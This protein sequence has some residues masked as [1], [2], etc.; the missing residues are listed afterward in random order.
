MKGALKLGRRVTFKE[1][2]NAVNVIENTIV[3]SGQMLK[4][5]HKLLNIESSYKGTLGALVRKVRNVDVQPSYRPGTL[6]SL[7][8]LFYQVTFC[9]LP[10]VNQSQVRRKPANQ[11]IN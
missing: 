6:S 1:K 5:N 7:F 11:Q 3:E 9:S 8:F 10:K 4:Q 2:D